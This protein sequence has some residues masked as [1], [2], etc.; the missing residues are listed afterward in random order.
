M[1]QQKNDTLVIVLL[2]AGALAYA[3]HTGDLQLPEMPREQPV[4]TS[5]EFNKSDLYRALAG[6]VEANRVEDTDRLLSIADNVGSRHELDVKA[7]I[8]SRCGFEAGKPKA[9]IAD[10]SYAKQVAEKLRG[11]M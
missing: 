2:V 7:E 9:L 10:P 3:W 6:M 11:G 1:Q 4:A 5:A 8:Q